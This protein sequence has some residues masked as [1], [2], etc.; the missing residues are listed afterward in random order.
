MEGILAAEIFRVRCLTWGAM[1]LT[2]LFINDW[3]FWRIKTLVRVVS[4][5]SSPAKR[6]SWWH[7]IQISTTVPGRPETST[8]KRDLPF[9]GSRNAIKQVFF[10][11]MLGS[12]MYWPRYSFGNLTSP[13]LPLVQEDDIYIF[14]TCDGHSYML[15]ASTTNVVVHSLLETGRGWIRGWLA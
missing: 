14:Q 6:F 1:S 13:G 4:P 5:F 2:G 9:K 15:C 3:E 7:S 11:N 10:R 12:N 8:L